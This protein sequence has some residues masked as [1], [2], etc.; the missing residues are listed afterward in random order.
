M[1]ISDWSS[2]VCSSDLLPRLDVHLAG[3][4]I[5]VRKQPGLEIGID[6]GA[7]DQPAAGD[8]VARI[9]EFDRGA[10]LV[11]GD[12]ALVDQHLA[13]RLDHHLIAGKGLIL[14]RSEERRVG[15]ECVSTCRSRWSPY[16]YKKTTSKHK[17]VKHTINI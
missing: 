17:E 16:H 14:G 6:P 12:D 2:D 15:K 4:R 10:Q 11:G 3:C 13:K 9:L 5:D 1:R 7:G 8:G